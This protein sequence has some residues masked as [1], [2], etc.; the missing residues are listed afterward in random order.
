MVLDLSHDEGREVLLELAATAD[1][2]LT[3]YLPKGRAKL[4]VELA[5]LRA[6]NPQIVYA[7]G[8][9]WGARGPMAN[10]AGFDRTA[11]WASSSMA[12]K[13]SRDAGEPVRPAAASF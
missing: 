3:S 9:G 2:F 5:D 4:G 10:T 1:V 8:S 7:S 12:I 11:G 13:M 6:A